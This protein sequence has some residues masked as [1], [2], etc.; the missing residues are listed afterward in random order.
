GPDG[1]LQERIADSEV[2][3]AGFPA[4]DESGQGGEKTLR[5]RHHRRNEN[6]SEKDQRAER[7]E[8]RGREGRALRDPQLQLDPVGHGAEIE[9]DENSEKQEQKNLGDGAEQP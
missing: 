6:P 8:D 2:I 4:R 7:Q 5:L 3:E 9:R 1:F